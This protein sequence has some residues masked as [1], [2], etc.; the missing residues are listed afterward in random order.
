MNSRS[1]LQTLRVSL[2]IGSM[3]CFSAADLF[4][5]A[6]PAPWQTANVGSPSPAG[7]STY[8][9][10][11]FSVTVG[12]TRIDGGSDQFH[13][14]YQQIAGNVEVTARVDSVFYAAAASTA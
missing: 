2:L 6:P 14:V 7:T 11:A 5:Q 8:D 13:F 1:R 9:G 3:A 4:A 12:G 10:Q